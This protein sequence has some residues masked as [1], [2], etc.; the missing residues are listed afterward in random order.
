M[1]N[2]FSDILLPA[3]IAIITLGMGLSIDASDFRNV[4]TRPKALSIGIFCQMILL[5]LIAFLIASL[6]KLDPLYKVGL[7]IISA[8]PGGATSN[9]VTYILKGHVALSISMTVINSIITLITIPFIV[10]LGLFHFTSE[11]SEIVLPIGHT[12]LN[13]FLLTIVPASAGV[14]IRHYF[15]KMAEYLQKPLRYLLPFL[16]MGVY[17]GVLFIDEGQGKVHI[18]DSLFILPSTLLL[19]FL[20]MLAGW[21]IAMLFKLGRRNQFTISIEVGLQNSSLAIFVAATILQNQSIALVPIIYGSFSFFSTALFGLG[22]K[23]FSRGKK[24]NI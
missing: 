19:N 6:T 11:G 10:S 20:S 16:L 17:F 1:Q 15:Q 4:F 24:N 5:P 14:F 18:L 9:L 7:I 2:L 13:V 8:C 21:G 22:V 12:I 23:K 3:T